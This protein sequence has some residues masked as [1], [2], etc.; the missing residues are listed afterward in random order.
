MDLHGIE[1][2]DFA[3][4]GGADNIT[5]NDLGGTDVTHVDIHLAGLPGGN[6]GD[7]QVDSVTVNGT[8]GPDTITVASDASGIVIDGLHAEVNLFGAEATELTITGLGG[9]DGIDASALAA[10]KIAL[11]E[12]RRRRLSSAALATT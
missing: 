5:V 11:T 7:G 1:K 8:N 4:L 3:A 6:T 2:I 12:W 10:G 9:A